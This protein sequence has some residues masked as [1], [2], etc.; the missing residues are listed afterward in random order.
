LPLSYSQL[1][2]AMQQVEAI[3]NR[4]G[5]SKHEVVFG[6]KNKVKK[7]LY[8][9][10]PKELDELYT[11][12]K[13]ILDT[14]PSYLKSTV[15]VYKPL[16]TMV[17][18]VRNKKYKELFQQPEQVTSYLTAGTLP[19]GVAQATE[20]V[21]ET[22]QKVARETKIEN[23]EDY[24]M[25]GRSLKLY[26]GWTR[27]KHLNKY[28]KELQKYLKAMGYYDYVVD[29]KYG[30]I[31]ARA[32]KE[33]TQDFYDVFKIPITDVAT[34]KVILAIVTAYNKGLTKD[35]IRALKK[36]KKGEEEA[37]E[38]KKPKKEKKFDITKII[39]PAVIALGALM[40]LAAAGR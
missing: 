23:L 33:F 29:G 32:V 6:D 4:V 39:V 21:L 12:V 34:P 2:S 8:K 30:P 1:K 36:K 25:Y 14:V 28:V 9:L 37:E 13:G 5:L 16:L 22:T 40:L 24:A 15:S 7:K 18:E 38:E 11:L 10:S 19:P 3:L 31:T 27:N 26:D 35:K 17:I 20:K